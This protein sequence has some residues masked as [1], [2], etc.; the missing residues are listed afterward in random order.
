M[1]VLAAAFLCTPPAVWAAETASVA[2]E[3]PGSPWLSPASE[4]AAM[5]STPDPPPDEA[6]STRRA[7]KTGM[8]IG[9]I[10]GAAVG[11]ALFPL[12]LAI[13][14][15]LGGGS[16]QHSAGDYILAGVSGAVLFGLAGAGIGALIGS[17][18]PAGSSSPEAE[19][20]L[21]PPPAP[22]PESEEPPGSDSRGSV[23]SVVLAVGVD[24]LTETQNTTQSTS[25]LSGRVSLLGDF[26]AGRL[27]LGVEAGYSGVRD[28]LFNLGGVVQVVLTEEG[29]RPYGV[30]DLRW[31]YWTAP[32]SPSL[33]GAGIGAGLSYRIGSSGTSLVLESRYNWPLQNFD[34]PGDFSYVSVALGPRFSW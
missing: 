32:S 6:T 19:T 31:D 8:W 25:G 10:T 5:D 3:R 12:G 18:F 29:L 23:G 15:S 24:A 22:L 13:D 33:L 2:L 1:A 26:A 30:F 7:T 28:G 21:P 34:E 9:G 4:V 17:A 16:N 27:S 11:A 14:E 20:P